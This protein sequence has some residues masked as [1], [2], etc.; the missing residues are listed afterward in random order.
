MSRA[1]AATA[2]DQAKASQ[3]A[4][5]ALQT[6]A[7]NMASTNTGLLENMLNTGYTPDQMYSM[8]TREMGAA[9]AP[10]ATAGTEAENEAARTRNASGTEALQDKLALQKGQA[11]GNQATNLQGQFTNQLNHNRAIG[12]QGLQDM[13][14]TEQ[15]AALGYNS[16]VAPL[17]NANTQASQNPWVS[18][19]S[20]ALGAAGQVGAAAITG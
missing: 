20:N 9:A 16:A 6:A 18:V 15:N 4:Q 2:E 5:A 11:M 17:V 3:A 13:Y 7:S 19:L 10:F 1:G 14:N 12:L 8:T